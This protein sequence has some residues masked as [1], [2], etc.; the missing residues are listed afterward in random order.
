MAAGMALVP[1][2]RKTQGLILPLTVREN[3]TLP[4]LPEVSRSGDRLDGSGSCRDRRRCATALAI[5][6]AGPE[7]PVRYLSGGN[8]QKVAIA[9]WLLTDADVYLLYDPTRG[10][11]VGAKQE[12]YELMRR[13]GG[14]RATASSSSR[15]T[16][17]R[18]SA[19]A[20]G[21]W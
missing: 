8:Q 12:I 6:M 4:T 15:P 14:A 19:S 16:W 7:A 17:P 10:I 13:A 3:I 5:R 21:R 11:D 18:S 2:D 20:I 9:K 1:E